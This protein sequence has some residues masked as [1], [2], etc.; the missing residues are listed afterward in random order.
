MPHHLVLCGKRGPKILLVTL[1]PGQ[2]P[3]TLTLWY[4]VLRVGREREGTAAEEAKRP[5]KGLG[6]GQGGTGLRS[7]GLVGLG[8]AVTVTA[9]PRR[10]RGVLR[11]LERGGGVIC[12]SVR[13][14]RAAGG[15]Q[16]EKLLGSFGLSPV[17][18]AVHLLVRAVASTFPGHSARHDKRQV[19][20]PGD[21]GTGSAWPA[22]VAKYSSHTLKCEGL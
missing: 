11:G 5:Q 4:Q 8:G 17:C 9:V 10:W 2:G 7:P 20:S 18:F 21:R 1:F 6:G 13:P 16:E 12:R 14:S 15:Q 19:P 3:K 22:R